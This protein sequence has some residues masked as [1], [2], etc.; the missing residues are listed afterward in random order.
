MTDVHTQL[1]ANFF[2]LFYFALFKLDMLYMVNLINI[3]LDHCRGDV[4]AKTGSDEDIVYA[5]IGTF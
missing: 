4:I 5:E 1:V 3:I 2:F